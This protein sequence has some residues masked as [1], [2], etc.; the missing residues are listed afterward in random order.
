MFIVGTILTLE[1]QRGDTFRDCRSSGA[2]F[3]GA[4]FYKHFAPNGTER[5]RARR[6]INAEMTTR[7]GCGHRDCAHE[8]LRQLMRNFFA[9][10]FNWRARKPKPPGLFASYVNHYNGQAKTMSGRDSLRNNTYYDR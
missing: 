2:L 5:T 3:L 7:D 10:L 6:C 1:P 4:V 9:R 8:T